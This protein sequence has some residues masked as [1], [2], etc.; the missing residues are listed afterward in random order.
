[1]VI[2]S[3]LPHAEFGL[4]DNREDAPLFISLWVIIYDSY[5]L[6]Q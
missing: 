1:M 5:S 4:N 6:E 3:I 2:V